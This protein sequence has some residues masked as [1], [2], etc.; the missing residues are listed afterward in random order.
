MRRQPAP[1]TLRLMTHEVGG[2][3]AQQQRR[4][5]CGAN[6]RS[7][8]TR[9]PLPFGERSRVQSLGST[10]LH[11]YC[12][13]RFVLSY[14]S[15]YSYDTTP[16]VAHVIARIPI[17][18]MR[19]SCVI[20]FHNRTNDIPHTGEPLRHLSIIM[21]LGARTCFLLARYTTSHGP[22]ALAHGRSVTIQCISSTTFT[23]T[24]R[25]VNEREHDRLPRSQRP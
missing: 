11:V 23:E 5:R 12:G 17:C 9:R 22:G 14:D 3:Q 8:V 19:L 21:A 4:W 6:G 1:P 7:L 18:Y 10:E 13:S 2:S 25:A 24:T 16:L 15:V 20:L